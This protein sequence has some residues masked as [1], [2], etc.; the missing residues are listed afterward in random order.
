MLERECFIHWVRHQPALRF[1]RAV[2][3][4]PGT[5]P[6]Q[7]SLADRSVLGWSLTNEGDVVRLFFLNLLIP[8]DGTAE[9]APD[10]GYRDAE[11]G[12][13]TVRLRQP[14][15]PMRTD[16]SSAALRAE[17]D[18]LRVEA[19]RYWVAYHER[20]RL[21]EVQ[22]REQL[23]QLNAKLASEVAP[24]APPPAPPVP[25]KPQRSFLARLIG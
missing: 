15:G 1:I 6:S 8:G 9:Y 18:L 16:H 5:K 19:Q 7:Y 12:D 3:A 2:L 17:E 21:L 14:L 10:P 24:P 23:E 25:P 4:K 11:A 13:P 20:E 22:R